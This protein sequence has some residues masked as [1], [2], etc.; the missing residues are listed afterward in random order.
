MV[1][2]KSAFLFV[3]SSIF[4]TNFVLCAAHRRP[5]TRDTGIDIHTLL[6]LLFALR[7]VYGRRGQKTKHIISP[8]MQPVI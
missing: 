5:N 7:A 3:F 1:Q 6:L 4:F 2:N 8:D